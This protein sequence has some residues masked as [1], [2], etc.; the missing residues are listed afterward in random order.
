[1]S[2]PSDGMIAVNQFGKWGFIDFAGNEVIPPKYQGKND[3]KDLM[4]YSYFKN[5]RAVVFDQNITKIIDKQGNEVFTAEAINTNDYYNKTNSAVLYN[6]LVVVHKVE[7]HEIPKLKIYNAQNGEV[8]Y[9]TSGEKV[10][11]KLESIC[12]DMICIKSSATH[13]SSDNYV[14]YK[15][16][17]E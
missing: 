2:I 17:K 12:E 7:S 8:L 3:L 9:D 15:L 5:N 16:I 13:S 1:M 6:D 10:E 11:E 14:V 4:I